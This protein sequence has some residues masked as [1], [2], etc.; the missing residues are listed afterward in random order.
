MF[1]GSDVGFDVGSDVC[2]LV[3]SGAV[4]TGPAVVTC[5]VPSEVPSC[6]GAVDVEGVRMFR[7]S[8]SETFLSSTGE[9]VEGGR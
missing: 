9:T 2:G 7:A 6:S 4:V 5:G 3:T 1:C 8:K